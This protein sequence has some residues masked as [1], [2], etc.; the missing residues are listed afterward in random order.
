MK[1]LYIAPIP[2]PITGQSLASKVLLDDL[3]L[4]NEIKV[5]NL[6][7]DSS[8]EGLGFFKRIVAVIKI[9]YDVSRKQKE[10]E[11]IYFTISESLFGN[12]KDLFI[13]LICFKK[14][15]IMYIHLHGGS[16]KRLLWDKVPL[17][18]KINKIF[19]SRLSGVI[20]LG[21]SHIEIFK[22]IVPEDKIFTVHNFALD[23]LFLENDAIQSKFLQSEF[24]HVVYISS[25][26][27]KKGYEELLNAYLKLTVEEKSKVKLDF[28]GDFESKALAKDFLNM[29]RTEK[30]ITY[31]G[32]VDSEKKKILLGKA[33]IFCLPT[34]FF[35]GQP[36]SILEAYA[37]GCIVLT[38]GQNGI[39][40]IFNKN[41]N[42]FEINQTSISDSI[43]DHLRY[44]MGQS[45]ENLLKIALHNA[46]T[47][48]SKY[49]STFFN[50]KLREIMGLNINKIREI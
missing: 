47:S 30:N 41:E 10:A 44:I 45:S 25:M 36:I 48:R 14:L 9:L 39:L 34:L 40:D 50:T 49:R 26:K 38:T 18:Y 28:A 21:K 37:S 31:H 5:V 22:N 3:A 1:I 19:I 4:N 33:N 35:E 20:I 43:A 23:I 6:S 46:Q 17:I 27:R 2:P 16:I 7:K 13:Y 32:N 42:G 15:S 29:I 8:F 11:T 24:L 12:I